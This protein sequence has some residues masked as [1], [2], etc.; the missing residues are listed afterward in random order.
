VIA[1]ATTTAIGFDIARCVAFDLEVYPGRWCVGFHGP[2]QKGKL[3]TSIVDG[4]RK[5]LAAVLGRLADRGMTLVGYNSSHF[6]IPV[7]KCVLNGFDPYAPAQQII[8]DNRLS[9]PFRDFSDFSCDTIDLS[10]RL[11]R[12]GGF[13]GLKAV[14]ANLGRPTL[15]ELPYPP[16]AILSDLEWEDVK[17]YNRIDLEHTWALLQLFTPELQALVSLSDELAQDMRSTSSPQLV[18][19]VF[20]QAYRRQHRGSDPIRPMTPDTVC[21]RPV[22]GVKKPWTPEAAAWF[23]EITTNPIPVVVVGNRPK[24]S[25]PSAHFSIGDLKLSVGAG[26]LHSVDSARVYYSTKKSRLVSVDVASFYPSLIA[27]KGISPQAYGAIGSRTYSDILERR[28]AIKREAKTVLDSAERERLDVQ[29]TALKLVLNSTFGKFGD[30][31]SSL[32]DP[33]AL[34]AVTLSGQL[35]LIDLVERLTEAKVKV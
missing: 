23:L 31:Y 3:T 26:G 32:F 13:P 2:D 11:R 12:G 4:D 21:Y 24:P 15:Q 28:L 20:L 10:A 5:K 16:D 29:A 7:I 6:D 25:V 35:M 1:S 17:A 18:E 9:D 22:E 8:R 27:T 19:R 34:L 30:S 33:E 14:A